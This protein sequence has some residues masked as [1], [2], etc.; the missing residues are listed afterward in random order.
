MNNS[1]E[2]TELVSETVDYLRQ[3]L[4]F[5]WKNATG[6]AKHRGRF[7]SYGLPGSPDVIGCFR[8][9]FIGIEIK[10][11]TAR[12]S[13]NQKSF[14]KRFEA[15]GGIYAICRCYGDVKRL[16]AQLRHLVPE[17]MEPHLDFQPSSDQQLGFRLVQQL[18]FSRVI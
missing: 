8:S 2:H 12:Q 11:G 18:G 5:F 3:N 15:E 7:Y 17:G 6:S 9:K 14:Q 1:K 10:T 13:P 16:A 4:G